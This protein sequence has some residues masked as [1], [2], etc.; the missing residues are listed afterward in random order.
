MGI[1]SH[2][3]L[4]IVLST[5]FGI[6]G[7]VSIALAGFWFLRNRRR[8]RLF[9]RGLTPIGD[10]EIE[11]WK[12]N[13]SAET[14]AED[15]EVEAYGA[16]RPSHVSKE[17]TTSA[18]IQYQKGASRPSTDTAT[19][20]RSF[21]NGTSFSIELPRAPEAA[22]FAK[23]PNARTGLT[24]EAIPGDDPFVPPLKRQPSRLQ[25]MPPGSSNNGNA[26]TPSRS[27]SSRT[28]TARSQTNPEQWHHNGADPSR[29][30]G[31]GH[32]RIYSSSSIPPRLP[33]ADDKETFAGLSPPPSR[34]RT[35]V[36]G[37]AIG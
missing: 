12:V 17:S 14:E 1:S 3:T 24:D 37:Q 19:A 35:E 18:R 2:D 6:I 22:A 28:R 11:T 15:K 29:G 23:A 26:K 36:I 20:P 27:S 30:A 9:N 34:H 25:K 4:V 16:T 32:S 21:I 7:V 5:V 10:E 31:G 13:R 8:H 33:N